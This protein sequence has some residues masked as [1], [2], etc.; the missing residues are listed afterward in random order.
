MSCD[1]FM[2]KTFV[3]VS[4]ILLSFQVVQG[5]ELQSRI[6]GG[7]NVTSLDGFKHQVSI[8]L[9]SADRTFGNGH[10]CG[11]SL[12]SHRTVLTAGK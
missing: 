11:G 5:Q 2:V 1:S 6:V 3:V 8:R 10:R 4:L 7:F 9:A 12:I